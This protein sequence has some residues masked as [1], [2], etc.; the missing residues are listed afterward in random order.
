MV[1]TKTAW[2]EFPGCDGFEIEIANLSRKELL[3]L[4]KRCIKTK[5]DRKTHQAVE[6]LD[7]DKFVHEFTKATVK[8]WKGLKLKYLEELIL[9]DL[10]ENDPDTELAFDLDNAEQLV[11]NSTDFDNWINEVVFDLANFRDRATKPSV[12]KTRKVAEA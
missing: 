12:G 4:R 5:F 1:D 2:I 7:E 3:N 10:G 9:V 6:E 11:Q 8:N